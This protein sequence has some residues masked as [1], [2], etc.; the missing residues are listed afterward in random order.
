MPNPLLYIQTVLFQTI[1][2]SIS[3]VFIH[4]IGL[5]GRVFADSPGDLGSIPGH[6]IPKTLKM[7]LDTY[8]F[9]TQQYKVRIKG[10]VEQSR[11]KSNALPLHFSVVA[12]EKGDFWLPLTA[13]ANFTFIHTQLNVKTVLYWTIQFSISTQFNCENSSNSSN[14]V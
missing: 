3:I 5:V 14:S 4:N 1:Q 12:I 2:F 8:L 7:V 9:N 10:K 6:V 11:E 13:V